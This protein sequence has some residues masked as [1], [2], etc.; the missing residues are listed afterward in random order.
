MKQTQLRSKMIKGSSHQIVLV[1][2]LL[3]F[4]FVFGNK[5]QAADAVVNVYNWSNQIG[6]KT[7]AQFEQETGIKVHY[8]VFDSNEMLETKLIIG[9]SGYDIV[10]PTDNFLDRQLESDLY[11]PLDKNKLPNWVNL[12]SKFM[13]I[14]AK[15]DPEN[16]YAIPNVLMTTGIGYNVE[17]LKKRL[18]DNFFNK[19]LKNNSWALIFEPEYTEKLKDCGIALI[20]SPTDIISSALIYLHLDPNSENPE[21]YAKVSILINKIRPDIRYIHSSRYIDDLANG[22][23]CIALGWSGDVLQAADRAKNAQNGIQIQYVIPKEGGLVAFD[24]LAIPKDAP[25]P[26]AAHA[27][28]NFMLRGDVAAQVTNELHFANANQVAN[29]HFVNPEI[30]QNN[31]IYPTEEEMNH[32]QALMAKSLEIDDLIIETWNRFLIAKK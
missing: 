23:I 22:N 26:E 11:L 31:A 29:E 27:F 24:T 28:L 4:G 32:L 17:Q 12:D 25:H 18:G 8:E 6:K 21:D 2:S 15:H 5:S 16:R 10:S 20:D 14:M 7:I 13:Q 9:G 3:F 19:D 1:A 30:I